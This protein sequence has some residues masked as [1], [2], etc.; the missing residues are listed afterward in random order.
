MATQFIVVG[1]PKVDGDHAQV[2]V[3]MFGQECQL[4]MSRAGNE[5][6]NGYGWQIFGQVCGPALGAQS[7]K[8]ITDD[9][10]KPR[11]VQS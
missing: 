1:S 4:N 10:G 7:G 5:S 8:W 2:T 9:Q 11:Y 3:R 6:S